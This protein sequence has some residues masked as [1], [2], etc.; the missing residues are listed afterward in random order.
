MRRLFEFIRSL[1]WFLF[2]WL[3]LAAGVV[4]LIPLTTE[5]PGQSYNGPFL[6]LSD[7]E[8]VVRGRLQEH[9]EVLAG[10][11]GERNMRH[12]DA[13]NKTALYIQAQFGM[14]GLAVTDERYQVD[15]KVVRNLIASVPGNTR[16]EE[17]IV[18]GAHYDSVW[19]SPGANDNATGVAALLEIARQIVD[20]PSP[21]R[22]VRFVAFVNEEPPY[23]KTWGMGSSVHA[24]NARLRGDRIVAMLSLETIGYYSDSPNSQFFP[25]HLGLYYPWT[26]NFIGFVANRESR[27]L[28]LR[29][30]EV[31]R[32]N[33]RFPSEGLSAP[34]WVT[35]VDWSDHWSFWEEGY[36]AIMVT[37][38]APYRYPN[39]HDL[40]DTPDKISYDHL[41][42]VVLGLAKVVRELADAEERIGDATVPD[43]VQFVGFG[44]QPPA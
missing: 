30:V 3:V 14:T 26:G 28:L 16:P 4:I 24:R 40:H 20:G 27:D 1:F 38:T 35:G 31:F 17:F 21:R 41:A 39:Y 34:A 9:V 18:I 6:A 37:D 22:T 29:C 32:R 36:P 11:I 10:V 2:P 19:G 15:D 13:L 7:P 5:M 42:R 12:Y 25:F 44:L 33:T 43:R 8:K 23:F